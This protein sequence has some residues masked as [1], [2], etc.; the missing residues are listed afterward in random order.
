MGGDTTALYLAA[1]LGHREVVETL[2]SSGANACYSMPFETTA[3]VTQGLVSSTGSSPSLNSEP[4]NGATAIHVASE[5]GHVDVVRALLQKVSPDFMGGIGVTPLHLA[6]QYSRLSVA[7]LLL[8]WNASVDLRSLVDGST[9]LASAVSFGSFEMIQTLLRAGASPLARAR[10]SS[11]LESFLPS[12]S[13]PLLLSLSLNNLKAFQLLLGAIPHCV[14]SSSPATLADCHLDNLLLFQVAMTPSSSAL[15]S[16]SDLKLLRRLLRY[17]SGCDLFSLRSPGNDTIVHLAAATGR[18]TVLKLILEHLSSAARHSQSQQSF[19]T[20]LDER[21]STGLSPLHTLLVSAESSTT[22]AADSAAMVALL[23]ENGSAVDPLVAPPD[24]H[25]SIAV[26]PQQSLD[27]AT[28]LY[29]ACSAGSGRMEAVVDELLLRGANPNIHLR[30]SGLTP[31]LAAI[32]RSSVAVVRSLL[33]GPVADSSLTVTVTVTVADPNLSDGSASFTQ[34]PLLF[35]VVKGRVEV[36]S[37]LLAAGADCGVTILMRSKT[38]PPLSGSASFSED[39]LS[40]LDVA[41]RK[42]DYDLMQLLASHPNCS[43]SS[44]TQRRSEELQA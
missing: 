32:D 31:L 43:F 13:S 28:P 6:A 39:L 36:A 22:S 30:W 33:F 24:N 8:Q 9:A 27:G 12:A 21:S 19:L 20:I 44:A 3:R 5:N 38:P 1:Q 18:M 7:N 34:S 41:R 35:A 17:F 40:L 14:C 23:L 26:D 29:L 42:R 25:T 15:T 10:S 11:S 37:L 2:L 16:A 4:A